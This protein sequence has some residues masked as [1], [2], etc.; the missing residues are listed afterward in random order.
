MHERGLH[1]DQ[2]RLCDIQVVRWQPWWARWRRSKMPGRSQRCES[3]WNVASVA[4][5][6]KR[7]CPPRVNDGSEAPYYLV[8]RTTLVAATIDSIWVTFQLEHAIDKDELGI[9]PSTTHDPLVGGTT[10][11]VWT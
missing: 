6:G 2:A 3:N 7:R 9:T 10:P 1:P 4:V 5:G 8:D 11:Y